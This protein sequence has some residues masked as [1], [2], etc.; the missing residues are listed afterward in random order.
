MNAADILNRRWP[1]PDPEPF[2]DLLRALT[3]LG[4]DPT[5][6][7]TRQAHNG[8]P[9]ATDDAGR[10]VWAPWVGEVYLAQ[11]PGACQGAETLHEAL[12]WA[13][14]L[15]EPSDLPNDLPDPTRSALILVDD[16]QRDLG[17]EH[18]ERIVPAVNALQRQYPTAYAFRF[19]NQD[20]TPAQNILAWR[21]RSA[22]SSE[23][24]L[25]FTPAPHLVIY[26]K[27]G[28]TAVTPRLLQELRETG[29]ETV[30]LCGMNTEANIT[31]T[32]LDLFQA[33]IR[34]VVV[35]NACASS[36]G[37]SYHECAIRA[38]SRSI[39]EHN[40]LLTS[41]RRNR[42]EEHFHQDNPRQSET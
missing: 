37:S 16:M 5:G 2:R 12:R 17:N 10:S 14:G 4:L 13:C 8:R 22:G 20:D 28:Y 30:L 11:R 34:P 27:T 41:G 33:G 23:S 39:G 1:P 40:V 31:A 3:S 35:A 18:A 24:Y 36:G 29:V 38:L 21:E 6:W 19:V 7:Q 9:Y 26:E 32:A 15:R 42:Q 25:A